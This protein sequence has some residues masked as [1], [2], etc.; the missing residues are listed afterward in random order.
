MMKLLKKYKAIWI[1]IEDLENIELDTLPMH[2]DRYIKTKTTAYGYN[3][4]TNFRGLNVL[5]DDIVTYNFNLLQSFLLIL[6]LY[7]MRNI[8]CK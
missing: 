8:I 7:S 2:D 3:V 6:Y 5:G 4:Y 1:K